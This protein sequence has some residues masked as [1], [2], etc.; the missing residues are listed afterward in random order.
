MGPAD[1]AGLQVNDV[2][3]A[4]DGLAVDGP[5]AV[6][7]AIERRG[8]GETLTL[9]IRRAS[10]SKVVRLKPVDLSFFDRS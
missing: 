9:Q 10:E 8:V 5:A 3:T 7:S 2:I 1:K 4:V 6:V